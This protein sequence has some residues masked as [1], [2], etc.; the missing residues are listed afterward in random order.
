HVSGSD[1]ETCPKRPPT[2]VPNGPD[3][4]ERV[5][6]Q[7]PTRRP[8]AAALGG[9]IRRVLSAEGLRAMLAGRP[10]LAAGGALA[11]LVAL[12]AALRAVAAVGVA[13]PWIAP[14]E[15]IYA[16]VGQSF[17]R[18]GTLELLGGPT[19]YYSFLVPLADGLPPR[20]FGL[21]AGYDL[22]RVLQ[23]L[24]MSLAAVPVYLWGRTLMPRAWALTAAALAL[25]VPGLA[26]AGLVM[27]EV[28]F[29]PLLTLAAW[30]MATALAR[31]TPRNQALLVG[32]A[33]LAASAR[34]QSLILL[35]AFACAIALDAWLTRSTR[36]ARRLAPAFGALALL[37]VVWIGVRAAAG[38][39]VLAGYAGVNRASYGAGEAAKF[40]LYHAASLELL[41]GVLPVCAL[42]VLLVEG[43]R[44]REPSAPAAAYLAVA[45]S[46]LVLVVI[47]VG[48][49]ASQHVGRLA[50]R[51]LTAL[52]PTLFLAL[53]LWLARGAPR[54]RA[55][56]A[57][58]GV[59]AAAPLLAL[60]LDR[61]VVDA[62][63]PDAL[64]L[65]PL[66]RLR[67]AASLHTL[68]LV[69]WISAACLIL[70]FALLPRRALPLL[71]ALL[72]AAGIAASVEASDFVSSRAEAQRRE[73]SSPDARWI[74]RAAHAPVAYVY[75][76]EPEWNGVWQTL[77]WN[78][79]VARVYDLEGAIVPG[80]VPQGPLSLHPDGTLTAD[81]DRR[82]EPGYA[83]LNSAFTLAGTP[84]ARIQQFASGQAGL[85]LWRFAP[86]IQLVSRTAGLLPDGS[87]VA[88][89]DGAITGYGCVHGGTFTARLETQGLATVDEVIDGRRLRRLSLDGGYD[90]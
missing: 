55:T 21:G 14:D 85:T 34:L 87:I 61:F 62:A 8:A 79:R 54:P 10:A 25:A 45:A 74:D 26:Y 78:R 76:G 47:E 27:T 81:G 75:D 5:R 90:L 60:P 86:P 33:V 73:F 88:G 68:E 43:V 69:F 37:A 83:V 23:A 65:V 48:V 38:R 4:A 52:A 57:A 44:R 16:L 18:H 17:W 30:A 36:T 77:F 42:L 2:R 84:V 24:A 40:V 9:I 39:P 72:V 82:P 89:G 6:G 31:P 7:G 29:Y 50:E 56:T 11:G 22:L 12:S 49:F 71:P 80:P 32:A 35:P 63:P 64:T 67:E 28:W 53:A 59:A 20:L 70:A 15:M 51:D 13:G 58:A 1:P 66:L 3:G 19:P 46:L 41:T